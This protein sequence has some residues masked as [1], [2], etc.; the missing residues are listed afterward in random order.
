MWIGYEVQ[1]NSGFEVSE[2]VAGPAWQIKPFLAFFH[3]LLGGYM[4]RKRKSM[5]HHLVEN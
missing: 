3:Y 4:G 2:L 1:E 5:V